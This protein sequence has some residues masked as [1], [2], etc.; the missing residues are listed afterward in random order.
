MDAT[1][2][3]GQAFGEQ[4]G[5]TRPTDR[6]KSKGWSPNQGAIA[7]GTPVTLGEDNDPNAGA[8]LIRL[9][10][11]TKRFPGVL[12]LDHIDFDMRAGEV[13]ALVGENGAGK[14][15]LINI[16]AGS[17]RPDSGEFFY[18]GEEI[19]NLTPHRARSLGISPVFQEFSLIPELDVSSNLF[20]GR[21]STNSGLLRIADMQATARRLLDELGFEL[22]EKALVS[23]LSRA[24]QQMVEIA[25]ALLQDLH[26]L[27]LDEPTASL[28]DREAEKLF[29]LILKLKARG[30]GII[31]VSHRM[32]EL[33]RIADRFTVL[34]DGKRITSGAM[35]EVSDVGLVE[36][37]TGRKIDLLFPRINHQPAATLLEVS[38]FSTADGRVRD[39]SLSVKAGEVVGLAGLVGCG[40][41]EIGRAIFGLDRISDG[42]L[43]VKGETVQRPAPSE[44]F[45]RGVCYFPSD[46]GAEG[47]APSRAV[48]ENA[49]M[50]AIRETKF[51]RHGLLKRGSE[52]SIIR[53]IAERLRLRPPDIEQPVSSLSGGNR[54]KVMLMRGLSRP[55]QV[56]I[57]D[58]PTVG[59]DVGA[60]AEIYELIA[61]LVADGAAILLISSELPE[62][63]HLSNRVYVMREG[64]LVADFAGSDIAETTILN[65]FF[66]IGMAG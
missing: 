3:S 41:S 64:S 39:V 33:R 51:S 53:S 42:R 20:L 18:R 45:A 26:L 8:N 54:Q 38:K 40:K 58:E 61:K 6:S 14:S 13:H 57:F 7:A 50:A 49:S 48:R 9:T 47:L 31:Y 17:R 23:E 32:A 29:E 43:V 10:G 12:A 21:E 37:M 55:T 35:A 46:R 11:I 66:N 5:D 44:M 25:K 2:L 24:Q 56:Y 52:R 62:I 65:A 30:V 4:I 60:K 1:G 59:I 63:L 34:R 16:I 22:D 27:I 36:L 19:R 28:T 15:T